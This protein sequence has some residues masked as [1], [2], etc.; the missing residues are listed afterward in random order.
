M[1]L[2]KEE[3]FGHGYNAEMRNC[4]SAEITTGKMRE[5]LRKFSA[6]YPP[7]YIVAD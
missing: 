7:K 3:L 1:E 2:I 6:F 4:G 5:L